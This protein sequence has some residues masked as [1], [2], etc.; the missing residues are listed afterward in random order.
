MPPDTPPN[1][2][3]VQRARQLVDMHSSK[4]PTLMRAF[5]RQLCHDFGT[6]EDVWLDAGVVY[7]HRVEGLEIPSGTRRK[8]LLSEILN[9]YGTWWEVRGTPAMCDIWE[10]IDNTRTELSEL[11]KSIPVLN[12]TFQQE[13]TELINRYSRKETSNTPDF[14]LAEFIGQILKAWDRAATARD[15]FFGFSPWGDSQN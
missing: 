10:Y 4:W 9:R 8:H 15:K 5:G 6:S 7:A 14:V 3:A 11:K 2:N 1:M 12:S 13:L